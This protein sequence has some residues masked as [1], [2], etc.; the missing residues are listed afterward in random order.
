[1]RPMDYRSTPRPAHRS[2]PAPTVNRLHPTATLVLAP[3]VTRLGPLG[4]FSVIIYRDGC[5]VMCQF[6]RQACLA[7]V[8]TSPS[9]TIGL[10]RSRSGTYEI[11]TPAVAV[12]PGSRRVSGTGRYP[13]RGNPI[14]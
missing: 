2:V 7:G 9:D 1:M 3:R 10:G 12:A 8:P 13:C 5:I 11:R 4:K 6:V 14:R